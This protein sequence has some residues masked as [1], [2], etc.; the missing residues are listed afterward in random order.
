M[1]AAQR[2]GMQ[3]VGIAHTYPLHCL[4]RWAN[5]AVDRFSDLELERIQ[6]KFLQE[7][8]QSGVPLC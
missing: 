5:W 2:A 6:K 8:L 4:Q 1:I 3:V 7:P